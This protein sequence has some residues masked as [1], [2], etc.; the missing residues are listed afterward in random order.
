MIIRFVHSCGKA[1]AWTRC[2]GVRRTGL[3]LSPIKGEKKVNKGDVAQERE[4]ARNSGGVETKHG[5]EKKK[6]NG[7]RTQ[8]EGV[9]LTHGRI[10]SC[11]QWRK[12]KK[13]S[14]T[15]AGQRHLQS[16]GVDHR[17]SSYPTRFRQ[18][19]NTAAPRTRYRFSFRE[20][21]EE[22]RCSCRTCSY[23]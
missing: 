21:T 13:N 5:K 19:L 23:K 4:R 10:R 11:A 6:K 18:T 16:W 7:N 12:N 1:G 3:R 20:L 9:T 17:I 22:P 15:E 2:Q 8:R 14:F